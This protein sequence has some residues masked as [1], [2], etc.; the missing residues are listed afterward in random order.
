MILITGQTLTLISSQ[1]EV[2]PILLYSGT[3][4]QQPSANAPLQEVTM[5]TETILLFMGIM[6]LGQSLRKLQPYLVCRRILPPGDKTEAEISNPE[7]VYT[8][9]QDSLMLAAFAAI[10]FTISF[11]KMFTCFL[12]V[13]ITLVLCGFCISECPGVVSRITF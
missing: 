6:C 10:V 8:S 9:L 5:D 11:P 3:A 2:C 13:L 7:T 1:F 4:Q 12:L